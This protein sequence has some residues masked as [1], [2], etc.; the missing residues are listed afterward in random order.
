MALIAFDG[1]DNYSSVSDIYARVGALQWTSQHGSFSSSAGRFGGGCLIPYRSAYTWTASINESVQTGYFG[2]ASLGVGD[3]FVDVVDGKTGTTQ[4]TIAFSATYG[5]VTVT[6]NGT[7][8]G[9]SATNA[10]NGT[11]WQ[12]IEIGTTV[13]TT[14]GS[15]E[16]RINNAPVLVLG[17]VDNQT[18]TNASFSALNIGSTYIDDFRFNDSTTGPGS[19]PCNSFLGDLRVID[20]LPISNSTVA[21]TP[22]TNTNWQEVSES[23]FDGDTTYNSTATTGDQDMFNLAALANTVDQI[24]GVQLMGGYREVNASTHTITQHLSSGGTDA[25][26]S[27]HNISKVY[28]FITDLFPINPVTSASWTLAEIN[29]L[30]AGYALSA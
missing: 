5:T 15:V 30:L 10:Y 1:F 19:Y 2:F 8:I 28:S 12:F 6:R 11:T 18:S 13:S 26:G 9:Q 4:F 14:A 22:L 24:V 7:Q 16:V 29:A 3:P 20:L 25:A 27:A 21:W 17:S 23:A